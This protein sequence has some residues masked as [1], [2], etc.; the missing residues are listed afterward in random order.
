[1]PEI[2]GYRHVNLTVTDITRSTEWHT[3]VLGFTMVKQVERDGMV[4]VLLRHPAT[5]IMFGFTGHGPRAS[6][7]QFS[8]FRTG[9]DHVAF[10]VRDRA[11][12]EAWK[13]RFE[14]FGVEHSEVKP[15]LMG[16]MI[17]FRD[18]DNIQFEV[19]WERP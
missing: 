15:S 19:Y 5:G 8:E 14:E 7:D 1:M 16:D 13:A 6:G 18:P 17:A 10:A 11:G 12:L 3:R 4:K 2:T 9:M